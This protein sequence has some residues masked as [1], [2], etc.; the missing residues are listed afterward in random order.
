MRDLYLLS[1][2]LTVT[3]PPHLP[4]S[5]QAM[6]D[7]YL[8]SLALTVTTPPHLPPSPQAMRDL[9]LLSL[10]DHLIGTYAS[11]FTNAIASQLAARYDGH[12]PVP[13]TRLTHSAT[14]HLPSHSVPTAH[15]PLAAC[16]LCALLRVAHTRLT[17]RTHSLHCMRALFSLTARGHA[18]ALVFRFSSH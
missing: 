14:P 12:A 1:L 18:C 13:H 5:P 17:Q 11:S 6:R 8:L 15:C 3:T 10:A 9:Y 2:T 4:P 16:A 7:L